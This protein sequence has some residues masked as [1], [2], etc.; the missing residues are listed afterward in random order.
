ME[1]LAGETTDI[2]QYLQNNFPQS[3]IRKKGPFVEEGK[4]QLEEYFQGLRREFTCY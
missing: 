1:F 3:L 4:K 2:V